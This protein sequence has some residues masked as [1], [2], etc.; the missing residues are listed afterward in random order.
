VRTMVGLDRT[1]AEGGAW[2]R[3][4]SDMEGARDFLSSDWNDWRRGNMSESGSREGRTTLLFAGGDEFTGGT[5]MVDLEVGGEEDE[6]PP[7]RRER[8]GGATFLGESSSSSPDEL[9]GSS[10]RK[11]PPPKMTPGGGVGSG[12]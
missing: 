1:C 3:M 5:V 12:G 6:R 2:V 11:L 10:C 7:Q 4:I 9:T 8:R